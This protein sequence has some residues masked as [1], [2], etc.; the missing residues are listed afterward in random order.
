MSS[1]R[2][3]CGFACHRTSE[4]LGLPPEQQAISGQDF[5]STQSSLILPV[6]TSR[7]TVQIVIKQVCIFCCPE[8]VQ[9]TWK[10]MKPVFAVKNAAKYTS[11]MY[12]CGTYKNT[13]CTS[14]A[15]ML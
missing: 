4:A 2:S 3:C 12:C 15:I 13:F 5:V 14:V 8:K 7:A 6:N 1:M 11:S 10:E 9:N